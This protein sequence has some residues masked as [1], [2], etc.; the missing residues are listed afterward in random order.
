MRLGILLIFFFL[1]CTVCAQERGTVSNPVIT[2]CVSHDMSLIYDDGIFYAVGTSNVGREGNPPLVYCGINVFKSNDLCKWDFYKRWDCTQVTDLHNTKFSRYYEKGMF[3]HVLDDDTITYPI[4]APDIIKYKGEYLVFASLRR[5]FDD[6]K[7]ALFRTDSIGGDLKF[8]NIVVSNSK[9]DGNA[10][11]NTREII[12]PFPFVENDS[13][14][15]VFGSFAR[16]GY[17]RLADHRKGIGVYIVLLD[18]ATM[19]M[20]EEPKF[21]TDYYEGCSIIKRNNT[22]YLFGT[23]GAWTNHTYKISY[24]KSDK[25]CGPY[26]NDDGMSI[27]DT[28]KFNPGREILVTPSKDARFNGFGCMSSPVIDNDGRYL[29][30]CH[31]HDLSLDP[32]MEKENTR[33]RY[34]FLL[35]LKWDDDGNPFFDMDKIHN[36]KIKKPIFK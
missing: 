27:V 36:N 35:E 20:Q 30:L 29:V 3:F 32:I 23:N 26:V 17:G 1:L 5:S 31:G 19:Q 2:G 28:I 22:Y 16:D 15:L 6:S 18:T 33:E 8:C 25:L 11:F 12:D 24:A 34:T 7:I 4:W 13:L 21:L 14:F 9:T 10:Y